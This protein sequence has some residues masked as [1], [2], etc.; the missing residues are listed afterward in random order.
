[1]PKSA[2]FSSLMR[3]TRAAAL[4][5]NVLLLAEAQAMDKCCPCETSYQAG[6][7]PSRP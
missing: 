5:L 3:Q 4:L 2:D 6:C 7:V 1:M